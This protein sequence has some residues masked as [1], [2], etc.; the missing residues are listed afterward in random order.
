MRLGWQV[1]TRDLRIPY[2]KSEP[3]GCRTHRRSSSLAEITDCES[4]DYRSRNVIKT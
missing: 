3:A 4:D 2:G 1:R